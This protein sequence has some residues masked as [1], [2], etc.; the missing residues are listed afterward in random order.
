MM[1]DRLEANKATY[2]LICAVATASGIWWLLS[3]PPRVHDARGK[4][5]P[6]PKRQPVVGNIANFPTTGW[7][8]EF[9]KLQKEYGKSLHHG[10]SLY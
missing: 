9:T 1:F 5:P 8:E 2:V 10:T 4:S 3:R 7:M 6:G